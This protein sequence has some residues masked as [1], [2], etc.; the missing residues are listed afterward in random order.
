[1]TLGERVRSGR[2]ATAAVVSVTLAALTIATAPSPAATPPAAPTGPTT[3]AAPL[4]CTNWRYGPADEPASLPPE[5]DRND[6]KDTSFRDPRPDLFGSPQNQCGQKGSAVDLAWGLSRGTPDVVIAILD[7]G[8][9]WRDADVMADLATKVHLNLGE[10]HPPCYPA[11]PTGDCNHDGVFDITDFGAI[12]DRNGNGVADPEDLI[13][14]PAFNNGVDDDGDGHVDD[15]AGWDFLYGDNDPF[16]TVSFGHGTGE[17]ED[18]SAAENG[19][20]NVG[21]CP[22]CQFIP[23]RVGDS[24]VAD[25]GRF[26]AGVLF[27]LDNG[28]DVIQEALGALN[29]PR[30]AQQ[31]VD[32]AYHRGVPI[33]ASMA[34]EASEHPNL[35]ASLEHTMDVNSVTK[36]QISL[37]PNQPVDGY[38]ALNGC[39]NYGGHTFVS[40]PSSSCSSEATGQSAGMMGLLESYA[41]QQHVSPHGGVSSSSGAA[42]AN[43]LSAD[44]A[45][46]LFR[47]TADDIDFSTPNAVDPAN[48][49]GTPNGSPLLD[50][51]RYQT[52]PGWD[53]IDGYGR[54][55]AYELLKAVRDGRIPPEAMIDGPSWFDVL[56]VTGSVPVTGHVAAPR[57]TS[58]DYRVEWAPGVEPPAFPA[59]DT[60]TTIAS[61][62][63]LTAPV[64]GTLGSLDLASVAASL[65]DGGHGPPIDPSNANR[66]ANEK[67]SVRLRVVVTAHGG[68]GDGLPARCRSRSSSTTTRTW[69]RGCRPGSRASAPPA[70]T[71]SISTATATTS[72]WWAPTT[73]TST[74][75]GPT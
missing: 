7:S 25:G 41:R 22:G 40:I 53:A 9:K 69:S 30:Q 67:F 35:P 14:D 75:T 51:V 32:A 60:W 1:M 48:N 45:M 63:G 12:A 20:G 33:V 27:A 62:T 74:P 56:P 46:Q 43:V 57:A 11:E 15:I 50:T 54:V 3:H 39:T 70:P 66:P 37:F 5:F 24:F 26:A 65:P 10:A 18:S 59:T 19:T 6:Y 47:S 16:D 21:T 71:S 61:Q 38:L 29:N 49:F 68:S 34:D 2:R 44:E 13:L 23:V 31:A 72:C 55:N 42:G 58:Y 36:K 4:D 28:A 17:A 73:E 52:R 64:D 8:I